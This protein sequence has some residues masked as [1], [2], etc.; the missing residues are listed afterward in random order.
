[1]GFNEDDRIRA[2][3]RKYNFP[4]PEINQSARS[5]IFDIGLP[6]SSALVERLETMLANNDDEQTRKIIETAILIAETE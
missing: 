5:L 2:K 3:N 4:T 6:N 1:M